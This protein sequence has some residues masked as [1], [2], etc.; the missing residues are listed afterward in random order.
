MNEEALKEVV[1][2]DG[3]TTEVLLKVLVLKAETRNKYLL[4]IKRW[5]TFMGIL[6]VIALIVQGC[7][8]LTRF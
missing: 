5:I 3:D 7:E 4:S 8:S 2:E 6:I 1:G